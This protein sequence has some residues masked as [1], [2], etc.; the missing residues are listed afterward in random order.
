VAAA[1]LHLGAEHYALFCSDPPEG[2]ARWT[3]RLVAE[4]GFSVEFPPQAGYSGEIDHHSA[5][6]PITIP[7]ESD[8]ASERSDAGFSI[9]PEGDRFRQV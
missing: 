6:K 1:P 3:V 2:R 8:Q 7:E 4:E 9:F 5:L